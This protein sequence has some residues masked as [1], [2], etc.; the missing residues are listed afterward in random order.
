MPR[1]S[2]AKPTEKIRLEEGL[3]LLEDIVSRMENPATTLD[4]SLALYKEGVDLAVKLAEGL[5]A[6]EGEVAVLTEQS[7]KIFEKTFARG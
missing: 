2:T 4:D 7:G 6:A 1:K 3:H 5:K